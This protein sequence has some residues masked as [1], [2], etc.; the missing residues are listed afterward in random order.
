MCECLKSKQPE[1]GGG[2]DRIEVIAEMH[3]ETLRRLMR[4]LIR[5]LFILDYTTLDGR[6]LPN[7]LNWT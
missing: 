1:R 7:S 4:T 6:L 3:E 5:N 2:F